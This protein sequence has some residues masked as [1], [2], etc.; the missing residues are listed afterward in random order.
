[1]PQATKTRRKSPNGTAS[2]RSGPV[3]ER[4]AKLRE[5]V[6][7]VPGA[8]LG[9]MLVNVPRRRDPFPALYFAL[10]SEL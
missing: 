10:K 9:K 5:L 2:L 4:V 3:A 8:N 6:Q 1:M 7:I